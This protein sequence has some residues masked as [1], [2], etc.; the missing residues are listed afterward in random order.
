MEVIQP[1]IQF[2]IN[3]RLKERIT[4]RITSKLESWNGGRYKTKLHDEKDCYNK[5]RTY[6]NRQK[7]QQL[8]DELFGPILCMIFQVILISPYMIM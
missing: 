2:V 4:R 1:K 3:D 7:A 8:G 6:W 5:T